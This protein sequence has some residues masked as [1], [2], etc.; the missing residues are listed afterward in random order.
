[1]EQRLA[2]A[3]AALGRARDFAN[4][5]RAAATK[6]AATQQA[7][8]EAQLAREVEAREA[9]ER[10]LVEERIAI[11]RL[12]SDHAASLRDA[13]QSFSTLEGELRAALAAHSQQVDE[14][15][16]EL[17][18]LTQELATTRNHRDA[19][20]LEAH[21]APELA[22]QLAA[23]RARNRRQFEQSPVSMLRC[24]HDGALQDANYAL[25]SALGYRSIDEVRAAGF[26]AS[27]FET[28]EDFATFVQRGQAGP[29]QTG[30]FVLMK[31][32]GGRLNMRLHVTLVSGDAIDI[33]AEDLTSLRAV[34]ERLHQAHRMEAVGRVA[35][36][37]AETCDTLLRNVS[38][39]GHQLLA[40]LGGDTPL[41]QEGEAIFADVT[42]AAGFLRQLSVYGHRQARASLPV[43]VIQV[44][45]DVEPVL[46]HVAG[47]DVELV[48]PRKGS[49]LNV[50]VDA[51]RV[52]RILVNVAA[53][54]RARMPSGGRLIVE[55]ARVAVDRRFTTKY[56]N[57][58]EGGH[59][60]IRITEVKAARTVWPI[61]LREARPFA[62][63]GAAVERPGVDL[64]ALQ[65]LIGDCGGHL[66]MNAEPGGN[67]EVKIRLPLRAPMAKAQ[68][69]RSGGK[70]AAMARWFQS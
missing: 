3:E 67:M 33:V 70:R 58:R 61:G 7:E 57:V 44:L 23:S 1:V 36:E 54:G 56:P 5:E 69:S 47:D 40:A 35:A 21:R 63:E 18:T 16:G 65:G 68:L 26:P 52:E 28:A 59:A 14:L 19:L 12:M 30:D 66:W 43:D 24:G 6:Q 38:R 25:V 11:E 10:D 48:L 39:S 2:D 9:V 4:A 51:E 49:A 41:R 22:R 31:K 32:D 15:N 46:R 27:V 64:G 13:Q 20:Q 34:E 60:L 53:Y 29:R 55:L 42:R 45:R 17:R 62:G 50:D 37:T 8:F